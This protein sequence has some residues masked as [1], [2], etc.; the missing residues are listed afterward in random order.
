MNKNNQFDDLLAISSSSDSSFKIDDISGNEE[1]EN[2]WKNDIAEETPEV[3][4]EIG[5]EE[6]GEEK[7]KGRGIFYKTKEAVTGNIKNSLLGM[8]VRSLTKEN[9]FNVLLDNLKPSKWNSYTPTE[10]QLQKLRDS[11]LP[12]EYYSVFNG[13]S[14]ADTWDSLVEEAHKS[15]KNDQSY[16]DSG[17]AAKLTGGI[18]G[19]VI[20]P[21]SYYTP[22]QTIKGFKNLKL[23]NKAM[24]VGSETA[25]TNILSESVR[26][27]VAGGDSDY[28]AALIGGLVFG[29]GMSA[30]S[31]NLSK[32]T[33][34]DFE[35]TTIRAEA[36][37]TA[38]NANSIDVSK[39]P[40]NNEVELKEHNNVSYTEHPTEPGAAILQDG[41]IISASNVINPNT[42]KEFAQIAP[43]RSSR[44]I[45]LGNLTELG[46]RILRSENEG[47]RELGLDLVR[48]PVG[49]ESGSSGKFGATASD[50]VE[51]LRMNDQR[52][53]NNVYTSMKEAL[54]DPEY[55]VGFPRFTDKHARQ[56]IFK[57]VTLAI[58][59]EDFS[60][61]SKS[62]Q[63][64]AD[65]IK[66]HFD[67]KRELM[68]NPKVF[69][70]S[71]ATNIFPKSHFKGTYVPHFYDKSSKQLFIKQYGL[72][73]LQKGI[74][75]SWLASYNTKSKVRNR[76][77]EYLQD[78][79]K[80]KK[81]TYE[82]V[83][84]YAN[85][86]AESIS[87]SDELTAKLSGEEIIDKN[88]LAGL[89]SNSF[90]KAR[91]LFDSDVSIDMPDGFKFSVNDLR[92]FDL[93][94]LMTS[95]DKRINGD[96]A[97]MGSSGKTTYQIKEQLLNLEKQT[98]LEGNKNNK[99]INAIKE[100]LK[101]I[102]GRARRDPDDVP[103]TLL[104]SINDLSFTVKNTFMGVLNFT[105][106]GSMFVNGTVKVLFKNIPI[107]KQMSSKGIVSSS[108]IKKI[109]DDI[110]GKEVDNLIRPSREDIINSIR[111]NSEFHPSL[112][113][114]AGNI[115]YGTQEAAS[116]WI[117]SKVLNKTSSL[118]LDAARQ[119][120]IGDI[121]SHTLTNK[122]SRWSKDNFL[123]SSSITKDQW[124]GIQSVIKEYM[125]KSSKNQ[126]VITDRKKFSMDPRV[127][128]LWRLADKVADE[129]L[130]RPNKISLQNSKALGIFG[131]TVLQFK[132]F[133]L[134]SLNSKFM[135]SYYEATKNHRE[136]DMALAF[137]ASVALA[138][139]GYLAITNVKSY[140]LPKR[141][142]KKYLDR[143]L[144]PTMIT[145]AAIS[146]GSIVGSPIS[147]ANLILGL[148]N[149]DQAK[150]LRSSISAQ[151]MSK[152]TSDSPMTANRIKLNMLSTISDQ[153]PSAGYIWNTGAALTNLVKLLNSS[154]TPTAADYKNALM[155]N[156]R[157]LIPN[158]LTQKLLIDA[159]QTIN[160]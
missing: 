149:V 91:H 50:I 74:T 58:E 57:K 47:I 39:I 96:I 112:I 23:I 81:V 118:L 15:Y 152:S 68:E 5:G 48:S 98:Q 69:G 7:R 64:V 38:K 72:S 27:S 155:N 56:T 143:A 52:T 146:R 102:T 120:V 127:M 142:R 11:G 55:K 61:L 135:R 53:Y 106:I 75:D 101:I 29:A 79:Y 153:I 65:L 141:K 140:T 157:E 43:D 108:E 104:K 83:K 144:D 86:T 40:T 117:F 4:G 59:N 37:E 51:R 82:M 14:S 95:Y 16:Q 150:L 156:I 115:Q 24:V 71:E 128:D 21:L 31:S 148:F 42:Q 109:H 88:T 145:Y 3:I 129:T 30:I 10:E 63:V 26:T 122:V 159:Y 111:E 85:R 49:M 87:H 131:K 34:N 124:A 133:T 114:L 12:A 22:L 92:T 105:E 32:I 80:V 45:P 110:F 70:N 160:T 33:A 77:D 41:S 130:L 126:Y 1:K 20:D 103:A 67:L 60:K 136:L 62:E 28:T 137:T 44:G 107:I 138:C 2:F 90:L 13:A 8:A 147:T 132:M 134:K 154:S 123:H 18:V 6:I 36:R 25:A 121:I 66:N 73:G 35:A 99:E 46:Y 76:V 84:D 139:L 119:G 89:E 100:V 17:W 151:S 78:V 94:Y 158:E 93:K 113:R 19:A 54:K 9:G 97:L 125:T 116:R